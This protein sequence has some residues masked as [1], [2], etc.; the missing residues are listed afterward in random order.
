[1]F[2]HALHI[3]PA[4][5]AR[6]PFVFPLLEA[7]SVCAVASLHVPFQD[8]RLELTQQADEVARWRAAHMLTLHCPLF[9]LCQLIFGCKREE[10]PPIDGPQRTPEHADKVLPPWHPPTR[11]GDA[12]VQDAPVHEPGIAARPFS[13]LTKG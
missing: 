10:R 4:R 5:R 11:R 7:H 6:R 1:M 9:F 13:E 2:G 3:L 12:G 8:V